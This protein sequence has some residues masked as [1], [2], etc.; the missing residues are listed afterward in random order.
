MKL[1]KI[2]NGILSQF[3][4][5]FLYFYEN[6]PYYTKEKH[7]KNQDWYF[8][9]N[10]S[11]VLLKKNPFILTLYILI[12]YVT[13]RRFNLNKIIETIFN[14]FNI[15]YLNIYLFLQ[16]KTFFLVFFNF[17]SYSKSNNKFFFRNM[18]YSKNLKFINLNTFNSKYWTIIYNYIKAILLALFIS[19]FI[20]IYL[21]YFFNLMFLKQLAIW[22]IIGNLFFWLISGFNF[23]LKR[24]AFS[25]F[26]SA[27]QRFWK[28]ANMCFW[29][30]EGFL[31]LLFYYYYLNSSQEPSYMYDFSSL[32]QEYLLNLESAYISIYLLVVISFLFY[33]ILLSLSSFVIYQLCFLL[34]VSSALIFYIFF[35]ESYQFYYLINLFIENTWVYSEDT[36]SWQLNYESCRYRTKFYY[37]TLCLIAKYWHFIF[38]FLSWIFL[39]VKFYE[40][41]KL[42]YTLFSYNMQNFLILIVLNLLTYSQW[43]KFIFRRYLDLVYFWFYTNYDIKNF[44]LIWREAALFLSSFLTQNF[45]HTPNL[46]LFTN[47]NLYSTKLYFSGTNIFLNLL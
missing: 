24:Y 2:F 12:L 11:Y 16:N 19:I 22:F 46:V 7:L 34:L 13:E 26:T 18:F 21:I 47:Y 20:F 8:Y 38:I 30:V 42:S 6:I 45:F 32:N 39:L 29:L 14:Y 33:F 43:I 37:M 23:F 40:S 15:M 36:N 44:Y 25:K 27:I 1:T 5:F 28:R 41:K 9:M 31:F 35:L 10:E 17:T 3:K 4:S